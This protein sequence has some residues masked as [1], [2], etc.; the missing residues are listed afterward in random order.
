MHQKQR[1]DAASTDDSRYRMLIEAITDYAIYMLDPQGRISSWN[2][3]ARHFKGYEESE[4]LGEHFSRFYTEADRKAGLPAKALETAGREGKFEGEGWRCRKDGT[5]FWAYVVIDAIRDASGNLLGF[6]KIT[7]DLTERKLAEEELRKSEEQFRLLVHG[8]TDYAIYMMT[9]AGQVSSWN[10]G[11]E[12]IKG[13][14][15]EEII[16]KHFSQFY[17]EEDRQAGIP[18]IALETAARDGRLEKEGWRIRKDG[19]KFLANVVIDAIRTP[20]GKLLG[21]AKI[22][23]DITER[24]EAERALQAAREALFQSQKMDAIGQ[25]TGGVAHDFNNLLMAVLGSLELLRKRLPSDPKMMRLVDNAMQGAQRGAALTQRML[26]FARRQELKPTVIDVAELVHGMTDLL[27]SS[28]GATVQIETDFP[29]GLNKVLADPN[30]LELAI[31]NLAVNARDAMPRGG[32]MFIAARDM[33]VVAAPDLKAGRYVCLSLTDE[34]CGMDEAARSR[35][36]EPFFTTKG[37]GKGTG[38]GLSMV[39]GMIDQSGGKL[40][41]KSRK[42]EGT[43]VELWLPVAAGG[44]GLRP[45]EADTGA[46]DGREG[47]LVILAVD[48]DPLVLLNTAA[49]LEDLGHTVLEATSGK[50][51]LEIIRR[52]GGIDLVITDQAMPLMTGSELAVAIRAEKPD[53]PIILATGY[54]ELPPGADGGLPRLSKPFRQHQLA[55]A[56][57]KIVA[58]SLSR[59]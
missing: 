49:M 52:K 25:L 39:H 53:L 5:R 54:A 36:L 27:H 20:D 50:D 47:P 41:L 24:R 22:T 15:P 45:D 10:A 28:L 31:L 46:L 3:G 9:P 57:A 13:Y 8:V 37:I 11:A 21:F 34:G 35:A 16:G 29:P 2:P 42:G 12:R 44:S 38:L 32:A 19:S 33:N 23:R 48:D 58:T 18:Q 26:A 6:A 7:R 51:A 55:D 1:F 40:V 17:T 56:I 59:R 14:R 4:I 43:T 30:Q